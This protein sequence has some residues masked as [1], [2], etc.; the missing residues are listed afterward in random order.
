MAPN[1]EAEEPHNNF[2]VRITNVLQKARWASLET[3]LSSLSAT[4]DQSLPDGVRRR[5]LLI[6]E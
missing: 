6:N 1:L 5:N 4:R 2:D 3:R